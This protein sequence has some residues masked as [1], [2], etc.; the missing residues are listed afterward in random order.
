MENNVPNN[1]GSKY[2]IELIYHNNFNEIFEIFKDIIY[3]P[4]KEDVENVLLEYG[5]N[6]EKTLYGY[7]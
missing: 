4:S 5:Q 3:N 7:F 2:I 1:N 6:K